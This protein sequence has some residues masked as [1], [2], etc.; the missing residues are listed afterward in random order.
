MTSVSGILQ[1]ELNCSGCSEHIIDREGISLNITTVSSGI[2]VST[3]KCLIIAGG[4][5]APF[6]EDISF[7]YIIACDKGYEYADRMGISYDIV[8]GDFDSALS[9]PQSGISVITLPTEKDDT[10]TL[11]AVRHAID[12]GFRDIHICCAFGGRLDH[13]I[14]NLQTAKFSAEQ[15]AIC[16]L[17]GRNDEL[18]CIRDSRIVLKK[19]ENSY[20]SVFSLSDESHGVSISG[21]KYTTD[22]IRLTSDFPVGVSNEWTCDEAVISV[23]NGILG[24]MI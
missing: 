9:H 20:I 6:K 13:T 5:Y 1:Y 16:H 15:G 10:D 18:H 11:Y 3:G 7:D 4:E 24:I 2:E 17:Y 12:K 8:M 14:A 19:R 21:T 22:S 23:S